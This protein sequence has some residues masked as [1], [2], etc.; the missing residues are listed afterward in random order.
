MLTTFRLFAA[1][2][3]IFSCISHAT[4]L[5][6]ELLAGTGRTDITEQS[7]A[8]NDPLYAKAL[9]LRSNGQ[10]AVLITVDAVSIG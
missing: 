2:T 1:M 9:V 8:F 5:R 3:V 7:V 10:L 6:G 4:Q